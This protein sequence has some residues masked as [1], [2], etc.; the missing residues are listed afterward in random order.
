V[1]GLGLGVTVTFTV[2]VRKGV[3]RVRVRVRVIDLVLGLELDEIKRRTEITEKTSPKYHDTK[4]Q[5]PTKQEQ[6][7]MRF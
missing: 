3:F 7:N 2:T 4:D 1:C 6:I 5:R